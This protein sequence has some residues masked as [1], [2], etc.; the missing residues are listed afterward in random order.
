[1]RLREASADL[2]EGGGDLLE[3]GMGLRETGA[4]LRERGAVPRQVGPSLPPTVPHLREAA[5]ALL[6]LAPILPQIGTRVRQKAAPLTQPRP[7]L[8]AKPGDLFT[9]PRIWDTL[10]AVGF[11]G[12]FGG[13]YMSRICL[14]RTLLAVPLFAVL[15]MLL[16]PGLLQARPADCLTCASIGCACSFDGTVY[17]CYACVK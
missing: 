13:R 8:P 1:V 10:A 2:R 7:D 6:Q 16:Y 14:H 5:A 17:T 15:G 12:L 4:E 3:T 9:L 11:N